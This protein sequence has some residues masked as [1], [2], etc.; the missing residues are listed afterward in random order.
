MLT[1]RL[2]ALRFERSKRLLSRMKK[3]PKLTVN[4]FSDKKMFTF[5]QVYSRRNN[6]VIVD[7]GDSG[8]PVNK[9]KHPA[10]VMVLGI[11]TSDGKKCPPI[12]VLGGLKV[13]T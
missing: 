1:D 6:H 7:Q 8:T 10:D 13:N 9:T 11:A 12:F 5:D 2:K 4:I 3:M